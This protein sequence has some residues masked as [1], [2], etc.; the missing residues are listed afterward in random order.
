M[1]PG[2]ANRRSLPSM[3]RVAE[4]VRPSASPRGPWHAL[5]SEHRAFVHA[6]CGWLMDAGRVERRAT[7]PGE[8][9]MCTRCMD[10]LASSGLI[11]PSA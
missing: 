5:A 11:G 4:Y 1:T 10:E 9:A 2:P 8:M 7:F 3:E 6:R